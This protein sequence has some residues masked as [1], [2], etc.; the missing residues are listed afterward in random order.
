MP[1][2]GRPTQLGAGLGRTQAG[3]ASITN[4]PTRHCHRHTVH[5]LEGLLVVY[6]FSCATHTWNTHCMREHGRREHTITHPAGDHRRQRN[7]AHQSPHAAHQPWHASLPWHVPPQPLPMHQCCLLQ[8]HCCAKCCRLGCHLKAA[9]MK[10]QMHCHDLR[11]ML[12][13]LSALLHHPL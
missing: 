5:E 13:H 7:P 11:P 3:Q 8:P 1:G 12:L 9:C 4:C 6:T 2:R 10:P